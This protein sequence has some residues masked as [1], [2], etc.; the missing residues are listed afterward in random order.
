MKIAYIYDAIYPYIKGGVEKR[1]YGEAQKQA[2]LGN[3]VH[4]YG[5]QY[6]E[7]PSVKKE[8]NI[9][10][11]GLIKA[12]P[13]ATKTGKRSLKG[14]FSYNYFLVYSLLKNNY[15]TIECQNIPYL[16]IFICFFI[17]FIKKTRI[18]VVW[19]EI[20]GHHWF[21]FYPILGFLG[22][23]IEKMALT[24]PLEHIAI[25]N[26]IF[27]KIP[28]KNKKLISFYPNQDEIFH[29]PTLNDHFDI[30]FAG[31]FVRHKQPELLIQTLDML[32]QKNFYPKTLFIG[33]GPLKSQVQAVAQ[34]KKLKN[35]QFIN[36]VPNIYS[37]LKSTK[38]LVLPSLREGCSFLTLESQAC[39][40]KVITIDA[41]LNA[42]KTLT[43]YVCKNSPQDLAT[44]IME[45]Y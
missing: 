39:N 27:Q 20:L 18:Q 32:A 35:V 15:D 37:Y 16:P 41:P 36:F 6:W 14:L 34:E 10:Y 2:G 28:S 25:S 26:F 44:K 5:Y 30:I 42:A 43:P 38:L 31:R 8:N 29:A 33:E 22:F 13:L 24:L 19:H 1:I 3:E 9:T 45:N 23:L 21:S 11:H 12:P 17:S 40:A 7:S 4:I